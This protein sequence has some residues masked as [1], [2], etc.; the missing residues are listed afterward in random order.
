MVA[1]S[2]VDFN[3]FQTSWVMFKPTTRLKL[4]SLNALIIHHFINLSV[5]WQ[6]NYSELDII[7]SFE[8]ASW[9]TT[10]GD[11]C[12]IVPSMK[13]RL[14]IRLSWE[15]EI[16]PI[17]SFVHWDQE[18]QEWS[19]NLH[20]IG[21]SQ[22]K[23]LKFKM[24][25]IALTRIGIVDHMRPSEM[26]IWVCCNSWWLKRNWKILHLFCI[27]CYHDW[28]EKLTR[29]KL[30]RTAKKP[31][32]EVLEAK[33]R[34]K[35]PV[36]GSSGCSQEICF[37]R[38]LPISD[39]TEEREEVKEYPSGKMKDQKT[40]PLRVVLNNSLSILSKTHTPQLERKSNLIFFL[41]IF[42]LRGYNFGIR[43]QHFKNCRIFACWM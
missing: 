7:W 25:W 39:D 27:I 23:I 38:S 10:L 18:W 11:G 5:L 36:I 42:E 22:Q 33:Q 28:V 6:A 15:F 26:R 43:V 14:M 29:D 2:K 13:P 12:G 8:S 41:Y 40:P 30:E 32:R 19:I 1:L 31:E 35:Q 21:I 24:R 9:T 37:N 34:T 20:R 3:V 16:P 17:E 4:F